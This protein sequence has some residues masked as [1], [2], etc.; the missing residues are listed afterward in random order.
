[1]L[2]HCIGNL[3]IDV[4]LILEH[5]VNDPFKYSGKLG[6]Q[7]LKPNWYFYCTNLQKLGTCKYKNI[8]KIPNT[9]QLEH[10]L[11]KC[12]GRDDTDQSG[13]QKTERNQELADSCLEYS[14]QE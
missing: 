10:F 8:N 12:T 9:V 11:L 7:A 1:M 14:S 2:M 6:Y 5:P 13:Q 3:K 4:I